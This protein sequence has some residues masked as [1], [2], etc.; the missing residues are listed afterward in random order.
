MFDYEPKPDTEPTD[1]TGLIIGAAT[2]PVFF[3]ITYF[4]TAE[5][6]LATC[7]VLGI[8]AFVVKLRWDLRKR[9]WFW[10]T[11]FILLALHVPLIPMFRVPE[12]KAPTRVYVFPLGVADF[13]IFFL[14]IN[15]VEDLFSSKTPPSIN[16]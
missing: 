4:Y 6:G 8:A 1:Y 7:L 10:A 2:L 14:T 3:I 12:G 15:F 9:V 11:L 13:A 5:M 16:E